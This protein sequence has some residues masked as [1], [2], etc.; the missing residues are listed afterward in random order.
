MIEQNGNVQQLLQQGIDAIKAKNKSHARE[1]LTQACDLDPTNVSVWFWLSAALDDPYKQEESLLKVLELDPN[2]NLAA[3]G[4]V[5]AQRQIIDSAFQRGV[6]A[7]QSDNLELARELLTEVV[8]RDNEHLAAWNWLSQVVETSEDQEV[9]FTNILTLD[10]ENYEIR[11]KLNLLQQTREIARQNPWID[12]EIETDQTPTKIAPTLAGDIL[13]EAYREKYT[14]IVPEPEYEP[15]PPSVAMWSKYDDNLG[16]PYCGSPTEHKHRRCPT[17]KKP[18]WVSSHSAESRSTLLWIVILLQAMSTLL[19]AVVPLIILFVVAQRLGIFN[20][21]NLIP[22]YLGLA[23][24]LNPNIIADAL[25]ILP[26]GWFFLSWVPA[27]IFLLYTIALYLRW[28]PVYY[29]LVAS[30]LLGLVGSVAGLVS[31]PAF[32]GSI[33]VW[34]LGI[35]ASLATLVMVIKLEG[36]FRKNRRRLYLDIDSDLSEG[37]AFLIR[38]KLYARRGMWALAAIHLRRAIGLMPYDAGGYMATAV[39]CSHLKDYDLARAVLED[40]QR[41]DPEN[42]RIQQALEVLQTAQPQVSNEEESFTG[43]IQEDERDANLV[44]EPDLSLGV[45]DVS[46]NIADT[47]T[48]EDSDQPVPDDL[49][50]DPTGLDNSEP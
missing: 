27:L 33:F 36:D 17:C 26:R 11:G 44:L 25:V 5:L 47:E 29:F 8:E 23:S 4:L 34:A 41:K 14:T 20:F 18:L 35:L 50:P 28:T 1:L 48:D 2:N 19:L 15:E 42:I 49:S 6:M 30:S 24:P 38:G 13:G 7:A 43:K 10:P 39:A 40:A 16:C 31:L 45:N 9:C 46:Q 12:D 3:K 32:V 22:A 37:M 21:F